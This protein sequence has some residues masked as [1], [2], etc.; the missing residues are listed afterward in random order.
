MPRMPISYEQRKYLR[1]SFK[2][3]AEAL[4]LR[5]LDGAFVDEMLAAYEEPNRR[6]HNANHLL[7]CITELENTPAPHDP[8]V[9]LALWFHDAVYDPTRNDSEARS[10]NLAA[11]F[12]PM[13][14]IRPDTLLT[15][16]RLI[17][18][19]NHHAPPTL[20]D[21]AL[22]VDIDLAILGQPPDTFNA[23]EYA[24]R[25]EY[26]HVSEPDFR[27]GRSRILHAFLRRK[28]IYRTPHFRR[29]YEATARENLVRSLE[30][31]R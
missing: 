11:L 24:V 17:L 27:T 1:A 19:T 20:R 3:I 10:A 9:G 29:R 4:S 25:Q 23:Y 8:H 16:Q 30:K 2:P 26:A 7:H 5:T 22:I 28:S 14:Q 6:Y 31:L 13:L 12:A 21:E 18:A 15:L